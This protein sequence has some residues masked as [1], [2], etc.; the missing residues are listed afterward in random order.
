MSAA[1]TPAAGGAAPATRRVARQRYLALLGW[2]FAL[3]NSV[4][5]LTYLPTMWAIQASGQSEQHSLLT[6]LTWVGANLT[7][8]GWLY[9]QN[10][11]RLNRAVMVSLGNGAM[12][13]A[14]SLLILWHRL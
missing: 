13:A 1:V 4:R 7:M 12:C 14:T 2:T 6:W 11:Q 3:F 5:V 10:G 8:A 9:E